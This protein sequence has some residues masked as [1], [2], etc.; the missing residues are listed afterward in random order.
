LSSCW[1]GM[2]SCSFSYTSC[3][4]RTPSCCTGR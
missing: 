2:P 3:W 1:F 4:F